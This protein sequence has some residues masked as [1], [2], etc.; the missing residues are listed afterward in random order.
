[1]SLTEPI[2]VNEMLSDTRYVLGIPYYT[3][4]SLETHGVDNAFSCGANVVSLHSKDVRADAYYQDYIH[5]T[6]DII[7]YF[8]N[9]AD[10]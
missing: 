3:E 10:I 2:K 5:F 7:K 8:K 1:M 4:M 6:S 9:G